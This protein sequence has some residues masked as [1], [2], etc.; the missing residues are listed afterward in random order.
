MTV[1]PPPICLGCSRLDRSTLSTAAFGPDT[2]KPKCQAFPDGIP[3]DI[4]DGG[5][6]HR[7]PYPGDNGV[8]F[9]QSPGREFLVE[10]YDA[11]P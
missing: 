7:E 5:M 1:G 6:D 11:R 8:L 4:W 10:H 3:S 2:D 9:E